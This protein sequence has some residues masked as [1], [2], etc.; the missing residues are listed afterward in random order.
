VSASDFDVAGQRVTTTASTRYEGGTAADFAVNVRVEVEG[1]IDAA[2]RIVASEVQ[3]RRESDLELAGI[4][5]SVSAAEGR[6]S[7]LGRVVR[8]TS[9]TRYEDH[10]N[11]ELER[12]SLADL[13]VGDYVELRAYE[14]MG[15][16]VATLLERD[17]PDSQ[18][19]VEGIATDVAAPNLTVGGV[20]VT[21]DAATE[22]KGRDGTITAAQ[23]FDLAPG[24]EVKI[25]GTLV[26]T[27]VLAER[28]EL[29]D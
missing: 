1:R 25:R 16:L 2:G 13:R 27:V 18:A 17:D 5:D 7:M 29:E 22:F 11:A 15:V 28:A 26:G 21:T 20:T 8:T 4:V 19:E 12:F 10:S 23:F 6:F 14:D 3:F 24:R 9:L